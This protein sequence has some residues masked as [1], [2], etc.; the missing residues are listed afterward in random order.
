M[1][2]TPSASSSSRI[3]SAR[4]QS[5]AA[6][7]FL[8]RVEALLGVVGDGAAPDAAPADD[9]LAKQVEALLTEGTEARAAKDWARADAIRAELDALSVDV[10]DTPSG[11]EWK[12]KA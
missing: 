2:S 9:G 7:A 6:R 1:T 10:M 5:L 3:A 12:R 11:S 8:D 4:A